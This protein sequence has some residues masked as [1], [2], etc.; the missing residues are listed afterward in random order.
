MITTITAVISVSRR[1]GQAT[2]AVSARDLLDEFGDRAE[3]AADP[4][5]PVLR[6]RR[7][8]STFHTT[9]FGEAIAPPRP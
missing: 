4:A 5:I 1:V 3:E 2:L 9:P 7:H 6:L 8:A